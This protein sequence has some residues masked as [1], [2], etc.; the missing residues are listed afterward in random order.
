MRVLSA[1]AAAGALLASLTVTDFPAARAGDIESGVAGS[2]KMPVT[3]MRER[4]LKS[5][6]LQQYDFSCGAATV[7]M[8]LTYH[9]NMP[10]TE[11]QAFRA[12]YEVGDQEKIQREGFSFLDMRNYIKSRKMN[13]AGFELNLDEIEELG[14]PAIALITL[15]G[16]RHFVLIKGIKGNR[17]LIGNSAIGMMAMERDK[18]DAMRDPIVVLIRNKAKLGREHFN[19]ASEWGVKPKAPL[20]KGNTAVFSTIFVDMTGS[21]F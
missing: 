17:V 19:L 1:I 13:A 4:P 16:Y 15:N 21:G 12:M 14:V 18:F 20:G 5:V 7:A 8:L 3:S 10:T 2:F 11:E 6:V 9:Y